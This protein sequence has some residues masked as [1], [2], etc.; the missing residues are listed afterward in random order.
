MAIYFDNNASTPVD[1][2]VIE[3]M[4]PY[5]EHGFG[6]PSSIHRVGQHARRGLDVARERVAALIGA[7]RREVIFTSGGTES[8]NH[9]VLGTFAEARER[10][11][12][13]ITSA[14]EHQAVLGACR[15]L[16]KLGAR[17]SHVGVDR[18]GLLDPQTVIDEITD[19]T[20][21]VSVMTANNDVGTIQPV[22]AIARATRERG[23]AF[24]SDAVQ[25][26]GKIPIDVTELEVDLLSLSS[27]KLHGPKGAGA[28]YVRR[29]TK[30]GSLLHGGQ[31]EFGLRGGTENVSAIVGFGKACELARKRLD[32]DVRYIGSLRDR[33]ETGIM[34]HV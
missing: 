8:D 29:G 31:H 3:E 30:I 34:S 17:V 21:L 32:E 13:L 1:P 27:H 7:R 15:A 24:H 4:L 20:V 6:N 23:V 28:L 19:D 25:A 9:A 16:E 5:L 26:V 14:I 22:A 33:L 10:G 18:E 2:E 11:N 12:H